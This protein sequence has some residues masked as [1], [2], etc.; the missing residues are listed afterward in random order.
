VDQGGGKDVSPPETGKKDIAMPLDLGPPDLPPDLPGAADEAEP[1]D[2]APPEPDLPAVPDVAMVCNY[3][4][5][6][7][8]VGGQ[9]QPDDCNVCVCLSIGDFACTSRVCVVDAGYFG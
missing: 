4:G 5:N 6:D 7:Y 9:Y 1:A 3:A 2:T 8:P